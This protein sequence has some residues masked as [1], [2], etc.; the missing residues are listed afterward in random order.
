V[1]TRESDRVVQFQL[2]VPASQSLVNRGDALSPDGAQLVFVAEGP[3]GRDVL[4][5]RRLERLE[6][7]PLPGTEGAYS[8]FWSPDSES[9]A[10]FADGRLKRTS[11]SGGDVQVICEVVAPAALPAGAWGADGTIIF[12]QTFG[13]IHKV[14]AQG[15]EST[16]VTTVN[17]GRGEFGHYNPAFLPDGVHFAY[18]VG[19]VPERL[20]IH[21]GSLASSE[22]L[23]LLPRSASFTITSNGF[24][25][26]IDSGVLRAQR[27]DLGRLQTVGESLVLANGVASVSASS[28]AIAY[29][30]A[31]STLTQLSWFDRSGK[32]IGTVGPP[33]NYLAPVLSPDQS[34]VAVARD[35]DIWI[36]DLA[37]GAEFRLTSDPSPEL[38]PLWSP[39]GTDI[40]YSGGVVG[41]LRRRAASGVGSEDVILDTGAIPW[42]WSADGRFI[43]YAVGSP[44]TFLDVYVLPLFGERRPQLYLQTRFQDADPALSP[45]GTR[46]AYSS[47]LSGRSEIY[48][49]AFPSTQERWQ[50]STD[51]GSQ[52][53]WR[54]DGRE[55]FYV[56]TG[57][58]LM[59]V[60]VIS[61]PT[62]RASLPR[63]LFQTA[64]LPSGRNRY[65]ASRDGQRFLVNALLEGAKPDIVVQLNWA[66]AISN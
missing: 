32:P 27:L 24:L 51:G 30:T 10:F 36:L 18:E 61:N 46:M 28:G 7:M 5:V 38:W 49:Q 21:V 40:V 17:E 19:A 62:F 26:V 14:S 15:G 63:P 25:L 53:A 22:S 64:S 4:W 52:P 66:A 31:G 6:T 47:G 59:A 43:T 20:G 50:I 57:G 45:D 11:A 39:D 13:P 29:R 55:L 33:G 23:R 12:A 34:K 41:S 35:G 44:R 42:S 9:I 48:V 58:R 65:V 1:P 56:D 37:R 60:D 54:A 16:P 2:S 8:P 3:D